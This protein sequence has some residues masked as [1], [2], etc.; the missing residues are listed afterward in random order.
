MAE[1]KGVSLEDNEVYK[2]KTDKNKNFLNV[3]EPPVYL[4]ENG[5]ADFFFFF[6]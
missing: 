2:Y 3:H 1:R 5:L 6:G 4:L